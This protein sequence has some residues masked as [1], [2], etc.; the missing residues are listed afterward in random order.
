LNLKSALFA[1]LAVIEFQY[2]HLVLNSWTYF[3]AN[4]CTYQWIYYQ[5]SAHTL[6]HVL[7]RI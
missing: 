2:K 4:L 7:V 3:Q 5:T 1:L 6:L